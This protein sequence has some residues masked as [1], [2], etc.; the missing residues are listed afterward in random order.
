MTGGLSDLNLDGVRFPRSM[1]NSPANERLLK[2][3]GV[4]LVDDCDA[5]LEDYARAWL[6]GVDTRDKR[7][8][9]A[10]TAVVRALDRMTARRQAA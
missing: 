9:P 10:V 3:L 4:E 5:E 1:L 2:F 7:N 8:A 6:A